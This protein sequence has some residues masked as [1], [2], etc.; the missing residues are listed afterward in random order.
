MGLFKI[1]A[2][3]IKLVLSNYVGWF[4]IFVFVGF[5][6]QFHCISNNNRLHYVW[7]NDIF[8]WFNRIIHNLR[9][10]FLL[11]EYYMKYYN[12]VYSRLRM[13]KVK[14]VSHTAMYERN[15]IYCCVGNQ[16]PWTRLY[17]SLR[18]L[19]L[20]SLYDALYRPILLQLIKKYNISKN[21][22]FETNFQQVAQLFLIFFR[23]KRPKPGSCV[24]S[25]CY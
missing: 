13:R 21:I 19:W 25:H 11:G 7:S 17:F 6:L 15:F 12:V 24:A 2:Q 5:T 4:V 10:V 8:I 18:K 3:L 9:N 16:T 22:L 1:T 14:F 20:I 23:I